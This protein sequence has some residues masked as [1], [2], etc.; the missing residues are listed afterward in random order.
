[1]CLAGRLLDRDDLLE[2][3]QV[4][5]RQERAAVDDHVDLVGAGGDGRAGFR[6]LDVTE[7]R[8]GGK[9]VA[10]LA[11]FTVDPRSASFASATSAG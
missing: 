11:T 1:M 9:P 5:A 4:V 7:R 8:A 2:H 10:T 3:G 6:D